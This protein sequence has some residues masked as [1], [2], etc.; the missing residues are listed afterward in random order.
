MQQVPEDRQCV[1][2]RH[3]ISQDEI[4]EVSAKYG[5]TAIALGFDIASQQST[6]SCLQFAPFK[7]G[8]STLAMEM[9]Q[10]CQRQGIIH[11]NTRI[12]LEFVL[13]YR[14]NMA[15]MA[16]RKSFSGAVRAVKIYVK[17]I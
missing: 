16:G 14:T 10:R 4:V 13:G 9:K 11:L 3:L 15:L 5:R 17:A 2:I 1:F 7:I 8:Q 6:H 12:I